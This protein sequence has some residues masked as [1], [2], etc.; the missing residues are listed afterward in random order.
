MV[1]KINIMVKT[2]A[3]L[4][5][6]SPPGTKLGEAFGID[7]AG[8]TLKKVME[9]LEI[10]IDTEVVILVNGLRVTNIEQTLNPN[11]LVVIF[12]RLGGG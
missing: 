9:Q 8:N 5:K 10:P 4:Q 6:F 3:T 7:L 12:P 2:Y 11:D 1:M